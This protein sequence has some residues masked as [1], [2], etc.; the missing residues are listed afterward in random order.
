MV[1]CKYIQEKR[2]SKRQEKVV[3]FAIKKYDV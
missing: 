1:P 2:S 3:T